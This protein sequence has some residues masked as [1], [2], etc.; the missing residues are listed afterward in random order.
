MNFRSVEQNISPSPIIAMHRVVIASPIC[1]SL[2][3]TVYIRTLLAQP[4]N[5]PCLHPQ[6]I[7]GLLRQR[8]N[9][10]HSLIHYFKNAY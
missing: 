6:L 8:P 7:S 10:R 5:I 9:S 4:L 2:V 1:K 3:N